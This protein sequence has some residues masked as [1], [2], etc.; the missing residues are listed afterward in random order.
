MKCVFRSRLSGNKTGSSM[1][2]MDKLIDDI[3]NNITLVIIYVMMMIIMMNISILTI[4]Q[5]EPRL[6][7][8]GPNGQR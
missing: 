2:S 8:M 7:N 4:V 3:Y 6:Y 1:R 5:K